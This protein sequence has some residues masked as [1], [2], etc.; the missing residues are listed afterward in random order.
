MHRCKF[1]GTGVAADATRC[2]LCHAGVEPDA[3]QE[4][5]DDLAFLP[6]PA[7]VWTGPLARAPA[8]HKDPDPRS[9]P[10]FSRWHGGVFTFRGELRLLI[11]LIVAL[12]AVLPYAATG[13]RMVLLL[14]A[15]PIG[16]MATWTMKHV[17]RRHR[18]G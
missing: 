1:C 9:R 18:V 15:V 6:H 4:G 11:T 2:W 3:V 12:L 8:V 16:L 14:S 13:S 10:V 7:H 5:P 17:W